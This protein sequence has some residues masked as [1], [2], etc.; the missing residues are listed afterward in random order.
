MH[1]LL[2]RFRLRQKQKMRRDEHGFERETH[3]GHK[4][5]SALVRAVEKREQAF[6]FFAGHRPAKGAPRKGLNDP[7][8]G[9]AWLEFWI[10]RGSKTFEGLFRG[11]QIFLDMDRGSEQGV[12]GGIEP[13]A[14]TAVRRQ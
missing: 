12:A 3:C 10:W 6:G 1:T 14:A 4:S 7:A 2:A 8:R 5:I 9:F 11:R 13:L